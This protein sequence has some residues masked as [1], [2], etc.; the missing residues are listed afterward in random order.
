MARLRGD[1]P[2]TLSVLDRLIDQDPQVTQELPLTRSQSLR[3]FK[4]AVRRDIE[5]LLNTRAPL[6]DPPA[7]SELEKSL[8]RY[9]LMDIT[10]MTV[11]SA[12]DRQRLTQSIE[13]TI[14]QFEPRI[15]NIRVTLSTDPEEKV[16]AL[17]FIIEGML[18]VDP[19]PEHVSFDTYL[20]L[21]SGEYKVQGD[22]SAR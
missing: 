2:V 14:A 13:A 19:S 10:S 7:D 16:P 3:E 22:S 11:S 6:L 17:R 8:Y 4:T 21:S 20:E 9:G 12:R 1:G 18:R 5:W 15:A